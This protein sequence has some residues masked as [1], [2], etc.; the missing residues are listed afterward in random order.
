MR[1][2]IYRL[3]EQQPDAMRIRFMNSNWLDGHGLWPI[4]P[5]RYGML[6]SV[7]FPSPDGG[8]SE[9][10]LE[11]IWRRCSQQCFREGFYSENYEKWWPSGAAYGLSV[12]DIVILAE[13]HPRED[14]QEGAFFCDSIGFRFLGK[15]LSDE[16][17]I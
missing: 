16:F 6:W 7:C 8:N 2:I 9:D 3:K 17:P 12:G 15:Q 11:A 14:L 13:T 10:L 5:K 1:C 4:D